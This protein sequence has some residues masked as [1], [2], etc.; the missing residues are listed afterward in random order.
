MTELIGYARVSTIEQDPELQFQALRAAGCTRIFMD[1]MS[2]VKTGRPELKKC[3]DALTEGDTLVVWKLD[4][5]GRDMSHLIHT[6]ADLDS[7]RIGF[8][9][10]TEAIDSGTAAGRLV[11]YVMGALSEFERSLIRERTMAGLAAARERGRIGGRP[12]TV[13]DEQFARVQDLLS[14]PGAR[15][16]DVAKEVGIS[17]SALY[18]R[19]QKAADAERDALASGIVSRP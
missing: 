19:L 2:G 12:C 17:R 7:R 8:R 16:A 1:K 14:V 11:L 3:L 18:R 10:L 4:R 6:I 13:S 9:S 15:L 5:L